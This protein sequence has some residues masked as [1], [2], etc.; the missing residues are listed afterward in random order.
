MSPDLLAGVRLP[1]A[2][3]KKLPEKPVEEH[4]P[5]KQKWT[6]FNDSRTI[7]DSLEGCTERL[8]V[9]DRL[10]EEF[11]DWLMTGINRR[12]NFTKLGETT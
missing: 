4:V 12:R 7:D 11:A 9:I 6:E 1:G 5:L 10:L 3:K 2:T 8:S